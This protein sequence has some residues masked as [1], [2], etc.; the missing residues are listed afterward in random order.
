LLIGG[1]VPGSGP[2]AL[3]IPE[4]RHLDLRDSER[5]PK[6]PVPPIA[7]PL[8]V[9]D[10]TPVVPDSYMSL[11]DAINIALANSKVIRILNGITATSSGKTIYDPAISNTT[12][13]QARGVFDPMLTLNNTWNHLDTPQAILDPTGSAGTTIF[14]TRDDQYQLNM[15]LTKK[16]VFGGTLGLSVMDTHDR[17]QS[18]LPPSGFFALN[19]Q[20]L[21]Q[22]GFFALNPQNQ[23]VTALNYTQPLL[24]GAGIAAN[25]APIVIARLNTEVTYFQ[26]NDSVQELVRGVVEAYWGVV[27]A[28]TDVWAK[29]QQVEQGK[30]AYERAA[31]QQRA[32]LGSAGVAAQTRSAYYNFKA[33]LIASQANLLNREA[34]LRSLLQLP[35]YVPE[36]L[37]LTTP[38][39]TAR[40]EPRWR[41]VLELAAQRRPD[42]IELQLIIEADQQAL[43]QANNQALPQVDLVTQYKWAGL[44]GLTPNGT[45]L[46]GGPFN[47]WTVGVN[48]AMPLG[49]RQARASMR[50]AELV[51]VRDKANLQQAQHQ[52]AHFIALSLRN[53]A[54]FYE[55]YQA[56]KET[57]AAAKI[58]LEQQLADFRAGR[59]IYLNVLQAITDWGN[60]ISSE[61]QALA[62]YNTELATLERQTGTI[63]ETHGVRFVEERFRAIGPLG[64]LAAPR[65]YPADIPPGPNA[66]I[67]PP[68]AEPAEKA[69][70]QERPGLGPPLEEGPSPRPVFGTPEPRP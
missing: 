31:A 17:F 43:I 61:A 58:N 46:G 23:P 69:L 19:P 13:D 52:A 48:V 42:L 1:C 64:R 44:D 24:K 67:Y 59:G 14:G 55:Q 68:G 8:T 35:P 56:F 12:I 47:S 60:A 5:L 41:E 34:A 45:P 65:L 62:S 33:N 28:H 50:S 63:L 20:N 7:A 4:Q 36:R 25:V 39:T 32:G 38:H 30:A 54:Q 10:P 66:P 49:L 70:E 6:I 3:V 22:P 57:R 2:W 37:I 29:E 53:L 11:D 15:G 40:V 51:L 9:S 16:T 26:L 18:G 21:V 27:F